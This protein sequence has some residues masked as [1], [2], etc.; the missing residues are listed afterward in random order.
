[1]SSLVGY[2]GRLEDQVVLSLPR[3][4]DYDL[5][6]FE[7]TNAERGGEKSVPPLNLFEST[8]QSLVLPRQLVNVL[9]RFENYH[10][11]VTLVDSRKRV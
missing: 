5:S 2:R 1:M 11:S 10:Q 9:V 8:R 6:L 3:I 4:E 7:A